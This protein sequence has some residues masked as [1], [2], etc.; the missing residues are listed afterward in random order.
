[1]LEGLFNKFRRNKEEDFYKKFD[2]SDVD[3]DIKTEKAQKAAEEAKEW[4]D[5]EFAA[6]R[7][8]A[9]E[10]PETLRDEDLIPV[11]PEDEDFIKPADPKRDERQK[12]N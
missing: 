3:A 5:E 7:A 6:R 8:A 2:V 9:E 1:M 11:K 10:Q 12:K 4:E